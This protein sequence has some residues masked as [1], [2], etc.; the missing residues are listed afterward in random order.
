MDKLDS[1]TWE[2]Y[3]FRNNLFVIKYVKKVRKYI[4]KENKILEERI[5]DD[6]TIPIHSNFKPRDYDA[7]GYNNTITIYG[8]ETSNIGFMDF[9]MYELY[10]LRTRYNL[11][12]FSDRISKVEIEQMTKEREEDINRQDWLFTQLTYWEKKYV[13]NEREKKETYEKRL[14]DT[15]TRY[16]ELKTTISETHKEQ[17]DELLA[18]V[19]GSSIPV[20]DGEIKGNI[21]SEE[22]WRDFR[23]REK[24]RE[25]EKEKEK[26]TKKKERVELYQKYLKNKDIQT[27]IME[28][29]QK[30]NQ[31]KGEIVN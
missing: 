7:I 21:Y 19:R 29:E 9:I 1:E 27:Q 3:A 5:I 24:E 28:L 23:E 17:L 13:D 2:E 16:F 31:L 22:Y 6:I 18:I 30:I 15:K 11:G 8:N 10:N 25:K 26:Q 4:D 20:L 12:W 14:V